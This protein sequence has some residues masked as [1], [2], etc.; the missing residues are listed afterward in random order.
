MWFGCGSD[1]VRMWFGHGSNVAQ[2]CVFGS[3]CRQSAEVKRKWLQQFLSHLVGISDFFFF[4]PRGRGRGK[5][6]GIRGGGGGVFG[7]LLKI[8]RGRGVLQE[9]EEGARWPGGCLRGSCPK[10]PA[11]L[12]ILHRSKFTMHSKFTMAQ[13]FT[14]ATPSRR[15]PFPWFYKELSSQKRVH[16]IVILRG[17]VK[18]LRR[19]NSLCRSVFSMAGS[20]GWG[21]GDK[22]FFFRGRN[23]HQGHFQADLQES[24]LSHFRVSLSS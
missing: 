18:T 21:W 12:K 20:F 8:P 5:Y 15:H 10:D 9:R 13:G 3:G 11:V 4:S 23:S 2:T 22:I 7:F 1:A 6:G 16:T 24:L 17:V 19:S 14:M